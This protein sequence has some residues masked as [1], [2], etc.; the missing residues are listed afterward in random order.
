MRQP[1]ARKLYDFP[2]LVFPDEWAV[3]HRE[4]IDPEAVSDQPPFGHPFVG[5]WP[6]IR[7]VPI[8]NADGTDSTFGRNRSVTADTVAVRKADSL[9]DRNVQMMSARSIGQK[10]QRE[11]PGFDRNCEFKEWIASHGDVTGDRKTGGPRPY[12]RVTFDQ[13]ET[14]DVAGEL[15]EPTPVPTEGVI[16]N[17][18]GVDGDDSSHPSTEHRERITWH[19]APS[20]ILIRH[21]EERYRVSYDMDLLPFQAG[22]DEEETDYLETNLDGELISGVKL[23]VPE[24]DEDLVK[25]TEGRLGQVYSTDR[26][27]T[28]SLA[29]QP[30]STVIFWRYCQISLGWPWVDVITACAFTGT[31]WKRTLEMSIAEIGRGGVRGGVGRVRRIGGEREACLTYSL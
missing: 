22:S 30:D 14:F 19:L 25:T 17:E 15:A 21:T 2:R 20:R 9:T 5:V 16:N 26:T 31:G 1:N 4:H 8:A 11:S 18:W 6:D 13:P 12:R 27:C 29:I 24:G 3:F 7:C 23:E 28:A 10:R